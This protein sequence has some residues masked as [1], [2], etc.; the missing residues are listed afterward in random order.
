MLLGFAHWWCLCESLKAKV[1]TVLFLRG[2]SK[3]RQFT[4]F[5]KEAD[6]KQNKTKQGRSF[7]ICSRCLQRGLQGLKKKLV[8]QNSGV[9]GNW[10][11]TVLETALCKDNMCCSVFLSIPHAS[12]GLW[13]IHGTVIH[14]A[15]TRAPHFSAAKITLR[16][17][18]QFVW[19]LFLETFLSFVELI[20]DP[21]W[22]LFQHHS[23]RAGFTGQGTLLL[24]NKFMS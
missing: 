18:M 22:Q 5:E 21:F 8:A 7:A 12:H 17:E 9:S 20:K 3:K 2:I 24:L 11:E 23:A 15:V 10:A 14:G 1:E 6:R 4:C 13:K 19:L 16:I